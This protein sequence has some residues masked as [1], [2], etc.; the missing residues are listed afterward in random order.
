MR[1]LFDLD[2]DLLG[3]PESHP[4]EKRLRPFVPGMARLIRHADEVWVSTPELARR[5]QLR[6]ANIVVRP[7][8]VDERLFAASGNLVKN[9]P[10]NP[11]RILYMGTATHEGDFVLIAPALI[12]LQAEFGERI[13]FEMIG[14]TSRG[15][16]G[17]NVKRLSPPG[18]VSASYPAFMAWLHEENHWHIGVA[19][20]VDN[21][22]NRGKSGIKAMDYAS[23]GLAVI[24]SD[25]E[26]Y[27]GTVLPSQTGLLV[28]NTTEAWHAALR[29]LVMDPARLLKQREASARAFHEGYA[30]KA[31]APS[32]R[33]TWTNFVSP[34]I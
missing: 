14:I 23:L 4:D 16:L 33:E 24:A 30:L 10:E 12:Q 28:A 17:L 19:P 2:D 11:I 7:N 20:L 31:Q 8:G 27:R 34:K 3:L 18:R 29:S 9:L 22:F 15:D 13:S 25:V 6:R 32:W 1:L 26:P 21:A 5:L